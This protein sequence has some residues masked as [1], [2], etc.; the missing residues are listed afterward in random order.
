[1]MCKC[2]YC[3]KVY[4]EAKST[5]NYKGYCSQKCLR[6]AQQQEKCNKK[7]VKVAGPLGRCGLAKKHQDSCISKMQINRDESETRESVDITVQAVRL[8]DTLK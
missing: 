5:A 3:D 2:R 1:M 6:T 8:R 4:H 7:V